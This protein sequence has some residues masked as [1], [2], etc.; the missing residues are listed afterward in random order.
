[1]VEGALDLGWLSAFGWFS[2]DKKA[3]ANVHAS[4]FSRCASF[5]LPDIEKCFLSESREYFP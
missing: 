2:L 1:M 5:S 4:S 3:V